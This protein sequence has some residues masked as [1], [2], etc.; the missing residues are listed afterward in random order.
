MKPILILLTLMVSEDSVST[1]NDI[2]VPKN[3][4]QQAS[5]SCENSQDENI[6]TSGDEWCW[7]GCTYDIAWCMCKPSWKMTKEDKLDLLIYEGK[8]HET[9]I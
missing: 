3:Y 1:K 5:I 9:I 2:F 6:Y 8:K 7:C 4:M